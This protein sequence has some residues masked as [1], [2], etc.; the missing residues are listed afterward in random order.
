MYV[1]QVPTGRGIPLKP[2]I[3]SNQYAQEFEPEYKEMRPTTPLTHNQAIPTVVTN[4]ETYS[5]TPTGQ[6]ASES[7]QRLQASPP[8]PTTSPYVPPGKFRA[9]FLS[10]QVMGILKKKTYFIFI[11]YLI[12]IYIK[13]SLT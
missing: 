1:L 10:A 7:Y 11:I 8:P 9:T 5:P 12:L 6:A 13:S 3:I 2:L 4:L